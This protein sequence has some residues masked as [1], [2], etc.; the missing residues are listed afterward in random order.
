MIIKDEKGSKRMMRDEKVMKRMM[1][2]E[3]MMK[4]RRETMKDE[5]E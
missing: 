2:D 3:K 5:R 1:G 4:R